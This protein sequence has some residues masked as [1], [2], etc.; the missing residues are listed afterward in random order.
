MN[1]KKISVLSFIILIVIVACKKEANKSTEIKN[2]KEFNSPDGM[3]WVN[4]KTFLQGA[5]ESDIYAMSSFFHFLNLK[6]IP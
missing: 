1:N 3:V 4:G 5:K 6:V 2:Q